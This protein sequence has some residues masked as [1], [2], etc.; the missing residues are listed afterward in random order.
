MAIMKWEPRARIEPLRHMH[1]EVDKFFD[2]FFDGIAPFG[3]ALRRTPVTWAFEA[4]ESFAPAV[5]LKEREGEYILTAELP[6]L[7]KD[8]VELSIEEKRIT[9][10]GERKTEET[11][12]GEHY[13]RRESFQGLFERTLTLPGE[14]DAENAQAKMENGILTL[15]LPKRAETIEKRRKIAIE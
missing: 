6:G 7:D 9:L 14:V 4:G 11:H 13:H 2:S 12:E 3:R 5:D 1:E 10:K 15:T 8:S